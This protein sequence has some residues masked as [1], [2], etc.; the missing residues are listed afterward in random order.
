MNKTER[1]YA[2]AL[3]RHVV[4][5]DELAAWARENL[6]KGYGYLY[7]KYLTRLLAQGKFV[8]VTRGMYAAV[9][10]FS[11]TFM[12]NPSILP[13][14]YLVASKLRDDYY[15][16]YHTA[17]ELHGCAYSV[18]NDSYVA[19]TDR[20]KFRPF[21]H[22]LLRFMC[23]VSRDLSTEVMVRKVAGHDVRVSS[24]SRTFV[25]CV[26]RPDICGGLEEVLKSL[27]GLREVTML[28]LDAAMGVY[29]Y[30]ILY[31]SVGFFLE[32]MKRESPFYDDITP[33]YIDSIRARTGATPR[34]LL[35]GV[36]SELDPRWN[37]YVPRHVA[38]MLVGVR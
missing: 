38:D 10:V 29:G 9:N 23:V 19:V 37:L 32:L 15:L 33:D 21:S 24:P 28:G 6:G 18:T 5:S 8:R 25:E 16:A 14:K 1:L 7:S 36:G 27:D 30:D 31:R 12:D 13:N 35:E 34:Y 11:D 26:R 2:F 4:T 20:G 22:D 17:L 3:A